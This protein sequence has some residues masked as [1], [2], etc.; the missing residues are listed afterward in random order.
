MKFILL[1]IFSFLNVLT[2]IQVNKDTF[3]TE[4]NNG[5][6]TYCEIL[7][8]DTEAYSLNIVIGEYN[9]TIY[10]SF[11]F[12]SSSKISTNSYCLKLSLI[13]SVSA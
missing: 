4:V 1:T 10:Y 12:T 6:N 7:E 9:E 2:P 11:V 8:K 13:N 5:Y 3:K